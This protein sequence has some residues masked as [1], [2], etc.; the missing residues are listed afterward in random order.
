MNIWDTGKWLELDMQHLFEWK[1]NRVLKMSR[2][3]HLFQTTC[4]QMCHE[5]CQSSA[6]SVSPDSFLWPLLCHPHGSCDVQEEPEVKRIT[7][8][9]SQGMEVAFAQSLSVTL[10]DH[11]PKTMSTHVSVYCVWMRTQSEVVIFTLLGSVVAPLTALTKL[12]RT[13]S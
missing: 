7:W 13:S 1:K 11:L 8:Y 10:L 9:E 12:H 4:L 6:Y 5:F 3:C 2:H